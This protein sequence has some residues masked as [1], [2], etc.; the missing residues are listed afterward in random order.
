M[1]PAYD[2]D[3]P[4]GEPC[5]GQGLALVA[6]A[7]DADGS[8]SLLDPHAE[9]ILDARLGRPPRDVLEATIVLEA[10]AGRP[11][12]SAMSTARSLVKAD[13][14]EPIGQGRV[15]P[16]DDSERRS[17][18]G[19]AVALV[20]S[21]LS[22]A[23]WAGPLSDD[24]GGHVLER[25]I[26]V[27]LPIAVALQWGLRSRY[28]SRRHGLALLAHQGVV[29]LAAAVLIIELPLVS[30]SPWGPIAAMLVAVW[31]AGTVLSRRGWGLLYA[32]ALV[33]ATAALD[34]GLSAY[35]VLGT[36][37]G[38][39]AVLCVIAVLSRRQPTDDRAGALSRAMLA[40]LL[41]GGIGVLLVADPTLGWGV[42]G[43]HP[44][45]ALVPSVIGSFWGGYHLWQLYAAIPLGLRGVPLDGASRVR[46]ADPAMK[47]FVGAIARLLGAT[48]VLSVAVIA[49][50][51]WTR[52]TDA[53][54]VFIAFGVVAL[55]SMLVSLMESLS[56]A[57]SAVVVVAIA[58]VAELSWPTIGPWLAAGSALAVGGCVGV[59]L[60]L[61]PLVLLLSRSGRV[62]ATALWIR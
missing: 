53:L 41:G 15:D 49:L 17:I 4:P 5:E 36:L 59:L 39:T 22:V 38:A 60:A 13:V 57:S 34:H 45:I 46:M 42:H 6:A 37:T 47:V 35:A 50:G 58:L 48:A 21:I 18:V 1:R 55:F 56:L 62:L 33:A 43:V 51:H 7:A 12:R 25:A 23:A 44:A 40:A 28:L 32:A 29:R 54:S 8:D 14:P 10:W 24:L 19:E 11:A 31:V 52:G 2:D 20:L 27:A 3:R 26:R 16:V 61:P 30:L 9:R